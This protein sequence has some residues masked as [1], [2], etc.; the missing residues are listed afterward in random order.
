MSPR[1]GNAPTSL[2]IREARVLRLS[3]GARPRRGAA[4]GDLHVLERGDVLIE[5]GVIAAVGESLSNPPETTVI[6]AGGR[7]LMPG[8]VDC[9]T[10]ACW[11]GDRLEEWAMRLAG[12]SYL[13]V[14]KAG[15]GIMSTVHAVRATSEEGLIAGL[16]QRLGV[17]LRLGTTTA[18]V[19]SGY[20]LDAETELK[21]LRAIGRAATPASRGK[22]PRDASPD[23]P[24]L[25]TV[26]PTALLGHAI[27]PDE[28]GFVEETIKKTLPDVHR[29]YPGVAVDAFC[30]D[31]AW[32]LKDAVRLLKRAKELGHPVRVHADQF[33][34]LGMVEEAVKLGAVSVDHLE[35]TKRSSIDRLAKSD[36]FAVTLPCCGFHLDGR[37]A[38][39]R[40]LVSEGG[41][42]AIATNY[43][44]GSAPCPSMPMAIA[45]AV[46][47]CGLSPAEA[48]SAATVNAAS[49]LG[50]IDR[51]TIAPGQRADLVLL[52]HADERMLACEFGDNPA[53][54]V[55]LGGKIVADSRA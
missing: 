6:E 4:L 11:A 23:D 20:G 49:L 16:R 5:G 50:L 26:V 36:T 31:G 37:F 10:H 21:M 17:M 1:G 15:G 30:E 53:D 51:G 3:R 18:E 40:R 46:R 29:A 12:A 38:S 55:V 7:V 24:A 35:A 48:I 13:D 41:L 42:L 32:S 27:D 28:P 47:H 45:L 22:R 39:P 52:R 14:L 43:N 25:P 34:D 44:P 19:K 9:H 33:S 54:L 2:L 8:F